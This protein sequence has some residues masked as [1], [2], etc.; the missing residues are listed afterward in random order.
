MNR[1]N[2]YR[3]DGHGYGKLY[4]HR[5]DIARLEEQWNR[6]GDVTSAVI[7]QK[8]QPARNDA[9]VEIA[10]YQFD[11]AFDCL[12]ALA[13]CW[14]RIEKQ[15]ERLVLA[16]EMTATQPKDDEQ[17][18]REIHAACENTNGFHN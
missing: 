10:N 5:D 7:K 2:R 16:V 8:K 1:V 14:E 9:Y 15:L 4:V 11:S 6:R 13:G 12:N 3:V 17:L 18:R